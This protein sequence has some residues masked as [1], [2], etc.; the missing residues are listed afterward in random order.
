[1]SNIAI[2]KNIPIP[3]KSS[4]AS[5]IKI[6]KGIPIPQNVLVDRRRFS[7]KRLLVENMQV[8]DSFLFRN[9]IST[10]CCAESSGACGRFNKSMPDR[11]Y[12]WGAWG[13]MIRIWRV[14]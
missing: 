6:D 4:S 13:T 9:V 12:K 8:G 5:A 14:K 11:D 3:F 10:Q 7:N 2:D 1:M